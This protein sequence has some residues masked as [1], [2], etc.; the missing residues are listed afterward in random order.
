MHILSTGACYSIYALKLMIKK[1]IEAWNTR[2]PMDE[3]VKQ[4]KAA[5]KPY[6]DKYLTGVYNSAIRNAIRIVK[7]GAE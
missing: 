3:I 2:K 6:D 1:A 7:G 4:L 5:T